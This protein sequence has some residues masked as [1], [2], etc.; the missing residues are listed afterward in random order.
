VRA[1]GSCRLCWGTV[2]GPSGLWPLC[3]PLSTDP[4]S[5]PTGTDSSNLGYEAPSTRGEEP[6]G[7]GYSWD[8]RG[9]T[10]SCLFL[11]GG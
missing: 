1:L 2:T 9:G 5:N 11:M 7:G 8:C 6:G 10:G 3:R 4:S